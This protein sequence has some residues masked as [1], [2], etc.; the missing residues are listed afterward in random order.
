MVVGY[1]NES[2]WRPVGQYPQINDDLVN[3]HHLL[4]CCLDMLSCAAYTKRQDLL[5]PQCLIFQDDLVAED[6]DAL[7][8]LTQ[9]CKSYNGQL[10]I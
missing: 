7:S 9:L 5:H 6:Q 10:I 4:L 3:S 1:P 8:V 2:Y